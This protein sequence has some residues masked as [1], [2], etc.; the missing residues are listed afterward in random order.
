M[1]VVIVVVIGEFAVVIVVAVVIVPVVAVVVVA[2]VVVVMM[3]PVRVVL[4]RLESKYRREKRRTART[5]LTPIKNTRKHDNIYEIAKG[6]CTTQGNTDNTF[7][8][9]HHSTDLRTIAVDYRELNSR[10]SMKWR[11][12]HETCWIPIT[13]NDLFSNKALTCDAA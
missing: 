3:V 7:Y 6:F 12:M 2:V 11:G 10:K 13:S 1:A 9:G 4:V 8:N 5:A